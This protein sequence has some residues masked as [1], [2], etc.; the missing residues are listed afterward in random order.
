L[1]SKKME[2]IAQERQQLNARNI[3]IYR[4]EFEILAFLQS[5]EQTVGRV[6]KT[7]LLWL[8]LFEPTDKA[9]KHILVKV[10]SALFS[11]L[12]LLPSLHNTKTCTVHFAGRFSRKL[13]HTSCTGLRC[14]SGMH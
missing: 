13:R 4:R 6:S 8:S 12:V 14:H 11:L 2:K 3:Y 5:N 9:K 10:L 7:V 1:F